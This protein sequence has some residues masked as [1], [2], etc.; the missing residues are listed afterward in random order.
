MRYGYLLPSDGPST[1][2]PDGLPVGFVKGEFDEPR[3]GQ[4]L[5]LACAACHTNDVSYQGHTIRIDGAPALADFH[6]FLS[7]LAAALAATRLDKP[8]FAR[9]AA[10]VFGHVPTPDE[11]QQLFE[12]FSEYAVAMEEQ[13]QMRT[14]PLAAGPARTDALG[15]RYG[16]L[17]PSDGPSTLNPDGLPVGFVKGEFDEP[18][19]G[20][21]LGLAC[22]ACHTNDVSYQGHTIRIDGAP[23][24]ADFHSFL[25]ELAA[26]LA[27]T[28]L[29]KPKFARFAANVFGH[30]P[31]P[32]EEQ[33]LF[34]DF[35]EYAV[36]MEEQI[37]MR[38]PPL[39]AGPART[40]ALGQIIN[41]L[42]VSYLHEPDNRCS[43][44]W[45]R[46]AMNNDF[47]TRT[48]L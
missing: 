22:A 43:L 37:Q 29:D 17:L 1:L 32:D 45:S 41:T 27:A 4:W 7:E 35:S 28:R 9:F 11:E 10:N 46:R 25:S 42:A 14:P 3:L 39:A 16:Y 13:I 23:A 31:T 40:D 24:L 6:S 38:T 44:P 19:L 20:Q 5:G 30:V 48:I 12:D 47:L 21:W 34:E 26:A 15:N 36:A 18:R 2:N 33:Q 8:K